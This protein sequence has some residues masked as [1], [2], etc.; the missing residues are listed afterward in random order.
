M[1][2]PTT[3]LSA[4]T[5]WRAA[6]RGLSE[7]YLVGR[8]SARHRAL[9]PPRLLLR[10]HPAP[11]PY[12]DGLFSALEM[13]CWDIIGK[14]AGQPVYKLL[15]GQVHEPLRSYTYLYARPER[16]SSDV[17]KIPSSP[18]SA[19]SS[20]SRRASRPSSSTQPAPTPPSTATSCRCR[21][22]RCASASCKPLREAVGT[23][24]DMLF[25]THG[26]MTAAGALRLARASS[27]TIRCGS[28]SR[29]RQIR[30][31]RWRSWRAPP[32][33]PIATGERLTH[34]VRIRARAARERRG[35]PADEP[36]PRRAASSRRRR[37]PRM[38]EV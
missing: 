28:R 33:I 30:P 16:H 37:S 24:A 12:R 31:R 27:P 7:R 34:Q 2:R 11:G 6:G 1:A 4:R 8:G 13:A 15:G 29:C 26:Q 22:R 21:D 14:E 9:L 36:R 10:L 19:R 38:A 3:H 35:H 32:R 17:Y 18:P 20:M 25:G 23:R 5:S